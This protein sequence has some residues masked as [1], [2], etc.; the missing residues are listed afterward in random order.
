VTSRHIV[1]SSNNYRTPSMS[2]MFMSRRLWLS[3]A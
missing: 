1:I 2:S 3:G